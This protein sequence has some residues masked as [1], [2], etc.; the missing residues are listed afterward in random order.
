MR[1]FLNDVATA[2]RLRGIPGAREKEINVKISL[3]SCCSK[4]RHCIAFVEIYMA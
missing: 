4:T 1:R 2:V 3:R